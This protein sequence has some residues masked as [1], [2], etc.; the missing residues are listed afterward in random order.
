MLLAHGWAVLQSSR[1]KYKGV[2]QDELFALDE[3]VDRADELLWKNYKEWMRENESP[4][5]KW[6]FQERLNNHHGLLQFSVSRNHRSSIVWDMLNW[7]AA[8]SES[9]YGIIY[10][11]DDEDEEGNINFGR[12][13]EDHSNSYR[14]WRILKGKIEEFE[15]RLLSPIVPNILPNHEA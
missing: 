15:D 11:H 9:T 12:G 8:N 7:L 4:Y 6:Q 10:V 14:V 5:L 1:E 3:Q 13:G 2:N